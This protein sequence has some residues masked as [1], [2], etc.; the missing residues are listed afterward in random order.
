MVI[1][2]QEDGSFRDWVFQAHPHPLMFVVRLQ[3]F[4]ERM[5]LTWSIRL[6]FH[7]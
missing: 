1:G 6:W 4:D 2:H 7:N 3:A 5:N